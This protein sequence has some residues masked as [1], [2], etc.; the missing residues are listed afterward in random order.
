MQQL[1]LLVLCGLCLVPLSA[2]E[3]SSGKNAGAAE[4]D[5]AGVL[6]NVSGAVDGAHKKASDRFNRF[7]YAIDGFFASGDASVQENSSWA[8]IRI[9]TIK[10]GAEK[11]ELKGTVKLRLVLPRSEKRFRLLLSSEE[12]SL[13]ASETDAAQREQLSKNK[14][15]DDLSLALRFVRTARENVSL[16]FDLGARVRDRKAQ[17]FGRINASSERELSTEWTNRLTNTFYYFS[18]SGY[19]NSFQ[20]DFRRRLFDRDSVFFLTNTEFSWREGKKGAGIGEVFGIY[21]Q[22]NPRTSIALESLTGFTTS[23]E[24]VAEVKAFSIKEVQA[25]SEPQ[26]RYL[27]TELRLRFRQNVW[28]PWFFYEIWPS[29]SWSSSNNYE[30]AY[31]GLVRVEFVIGQQ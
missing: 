20:I 30:R 17:I 13:S 1:G 28:R 5:E 4:K 12:E 18:A 22:L 29:V 8:R 27:G 21:A 7:V 3:K 16:S 31:G 10:P 14:K 9:D 25:Q 19:E 26:N 15:N 2:A 24:P 6:S 23:L 11:L